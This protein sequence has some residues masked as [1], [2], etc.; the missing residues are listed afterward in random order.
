[1][2]YAHFQ[3]YFFRFWGNLLKEKK[4]IQF[5]FSQLIAIGTTL[6]FFIS[7]EIATRKFL[8]F[9]MDILFSSKYAV[10]SFLQQRKSFKKLV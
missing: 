8:I 6:S 3:M 4:Q 1:M 7:I 10:L 9:F 5:N 2:I